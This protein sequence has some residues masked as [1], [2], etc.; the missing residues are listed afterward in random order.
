MGKTYTRADYED[1]INRGGSVILNGKIISRIED[2]P[3]AGNLAALRGDP[4]EVE[5][6]ADRLE[7]ESALTAKEAERLRARAGELRK[8]NARQAE[9]DAAATA[10]LQRAH[11]EKDAEIERLKAELAAFHEAQ[12]YEATHDEEQDPETGET[13]RRGRPRKS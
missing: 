12:G 11:A 2:L 1:A 9:A 6:E 5:K 4:D 8:E 7:A 3:T 13:R 10:D